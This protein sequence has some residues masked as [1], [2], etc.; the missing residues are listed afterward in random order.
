M[1]ELDFLRGLRR[2][3]LPEPTRQT[4]LRRANGTWYLDNDFERVPRHRRGQRP[5]ALRA[6]AERVR[7]PPPSREHSSGG[8]GRRELVR[9]EA[10]VRAVQRAISRAAERRADNRRRH[11]SRR[12]GLPGQPRDLRV[13]PDARPVVEQLEPRRPASP[14]PLAN[15]DGCVRMTRPPPPKWRARARARTAGVSS[16]A[17]RSTSRDDGPGPRAG[18]RRPRGPGRGR[19]ACAAPRRCPRRSPG[20]SSRAT[21]GRPGTRS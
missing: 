12:P 11:C 6:A 3:G 20:S 14:R 4:R 18:A 7:R 10:P 16:T 17:S 21:C 5:P 15:V 19:S 13:L 1:P 9:R 8:R 2:A